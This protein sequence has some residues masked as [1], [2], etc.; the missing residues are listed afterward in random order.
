MR[1]RVVRNAPETDLDIAAAYRQLCEEVGRL[2]ESLMHQDSGLVRSN[3]GEI[4]I[5]LVQLLN[6]HCPDTSLEVAM[7]DR[8]EELEL[9]DRPR[10]RRRCAAPSHVVY[11]V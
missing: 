11:S 6:G 10:R 1:S 7:E 5:A 4:G 9:R 2:G 8:L 3:A